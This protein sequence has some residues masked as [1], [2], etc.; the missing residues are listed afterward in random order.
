MKSKWFLP[1]LFVLF[2][3]FSCAHKK[4]VPS[5]GGTNPPVSVETPEEKEQ[6]DYCEAVA[7][8]LELCKE[9]YGTDCEIIIKAVPLLEK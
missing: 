5:L 4:K 7:I 1:I 6:R 3:G 2:I 8:Q 9:M